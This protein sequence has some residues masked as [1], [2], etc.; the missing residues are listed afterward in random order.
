MR[1]MFLMVLAATAA[2]VM[3]SAPPAAAEY[4]FA[5]PRPLEAIVGQAE[6][7]TPDEVGALTGMHD[8]TDFWLCP[9]PV[10]LITDGFTRMDGGGY[11]SQA[12]GEVSE[13]VWINRTD[14]I[15]YAI[16]SPTDDPSEVPPGSVIAIGESLPFGEMHAGL[17]NQAEGNDGPPCSVT[18]GNSTFACCNSNGCHCRNSRQNDDDCVAGGKNAIA[19]S[20]GEQ[21]GGGSG[22]QPLSPTVT[23]DD[24]RPA[25][26]TID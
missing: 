22:G 25:P 13:G 6:V 9:D 10:I 1:M 18:C 3:A 4:D 19:C 24:K 14:S 21:G 20:L 2:A 8:G 15:Q 11:L 5:Q 23:R 26:P 17:S 12:S 7:W 16:I